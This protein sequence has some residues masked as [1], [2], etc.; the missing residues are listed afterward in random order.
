MKRIL[1]AL[2]ILFMIMTILSTP[3]LIFAQNDLNENELLGDA[4]ESLDIL[5][6]YNCTYSH[7]FLFPIWYH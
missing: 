2:L 7:L 3:V 6:S 4:A 5:S 1:S